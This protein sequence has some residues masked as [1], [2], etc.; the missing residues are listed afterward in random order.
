MR[1]PTRAIPIVLAAVDVDVIGFGIL[2]PVLPE[3]ITH[4]GHVDLEEATRVAGWRL[5]VFAIAQFDAGPL[6]C[7]LGGQAARNG[8]GSGKSVLVRDVTGG[9]P[10]PTKNN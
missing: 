6:V 4:L 7:H 5:P 2:M 8:A 9:R 3:L 1:F 10:L